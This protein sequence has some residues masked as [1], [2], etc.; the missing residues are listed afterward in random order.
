MARKA[1]KA[2]RAPRVTK[3]AKQ[4]LTDSFVKPLRPYGI[5]T[6]GIDEEPAFPVQP[7]D[8][9]R[10]LSL[11]KGFT[12]YNTYYSKKDAKSM[13][14]Q[15]LHMN[16]KVAESKKMGKVDDREVKTTYGWLARMTLRGL[17]LTKVEEGRL[18][19][20]I[21][22]LFD[23]I[24]NQTKR[25]QIG[26]E[27][28][29]KPVDAVAKP[30]IQDRMRE[31][32][33]EASGELEGVLDDFQ[34]AGC[35]AKTPNKVVEILTSFN[36]MPQH[37]T[38]IMEVWKKKQAEYEEVL[39]GKDSQLV[40]AYSHRTKTQLKN[41]LA[42]IESVIGD[43]N[44]YISIKKASKAPRKR[45]VVTPEKQVSKLKYLKEFKDAAVKLDLVSV[46]P[47]KLIG[48]SEAWVYDTAKRKLYHFIA[49]E[50]SKTFSVKGNTLLGF[51]NNQSE[52]KTLRKP[53]EQIKEIMGSK[54]AARKYFKDIKA[55]S[56]I[57][58]GRFNDTMI[59]LKAF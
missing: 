7:T 56:A 59:I 30:N 8:N 38:A 18:T 6:G 14:V 3:A 9:E 5:V 37:V 51:D 48:A 47:T 57:P 2:P 15:Y 21:A 43:L 1:T 40:E 20:E 42:F 53:A 49:D 34:E 55:V 17:T 54:P 24:G 32:A 52:M 45:K 36:V 41:V 23:T 58:K 4:A 19:D 11:T 44:N 12:W 29:K 27:D 46:H 31:K 35:K 22:R 10:S 50:Y 39:Q 16:K 25:S 13:L 28:K 26:G 33:M